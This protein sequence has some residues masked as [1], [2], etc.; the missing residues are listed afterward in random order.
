[1]PQE[2]LAVEAVIGKDI[3]REAS[4]LDGVPR[5]R[6]DRSDL[7]A[8]LRDGRQSVCH[9][10]AA[11]E[12]EDVRRWRPCEVFVDRLRVAADDVDSRKTDDLTTGRFDCGRK[13]A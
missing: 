11:H 12:H 1:M 8:A 9:R 10:I 2:M 13:F 7:R 3:D 4:P 6:T 5:C